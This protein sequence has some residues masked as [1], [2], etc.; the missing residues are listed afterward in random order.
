MKSG[1]NDLVRQNH[2]FH[3]ELIKIWMN[4]KRSWQV[5]IC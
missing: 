3:K 4:F 5:Q 2:I 1:K